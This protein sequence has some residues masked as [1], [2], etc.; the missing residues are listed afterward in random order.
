MKTKK[1]RGNPRMGNFG[2]TTRFKPGQSGNPGG[3]PKTRVMSEMLCSIGNEVEPKSGKTFFQLA[4]EELVRSAYNGD[5]G[6]FKEIADRVE[7]RTTQSVELHGGLHVPHSD[8]EWHT[9]YR[10]ATHERQEQM[11]TELDDKVLALAESIKAKRADTPENRYR[12][13]A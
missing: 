6:A 8:S 7:G 4:A 3:R 1:R 13:R 5:V 9:E 10:S 2:I 11:S 12:A